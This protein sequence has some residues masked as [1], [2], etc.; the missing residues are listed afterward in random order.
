MAATQNTR[1]VGDSLQR[2]ARRLDTS[3]L[4][5]SRDVEQ[6]TWFGRVGHRRIRPAHFGNG[7][8]EIESGHDGR[9]ERRS[10]RAT[11]AILAARCTFARRIIVRARLDTRRFDELDHTARFEGE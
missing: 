2:Y 1:P 8:R 9:R 7:G 5:A 3:L 6:R 11:G 10:M 4:G